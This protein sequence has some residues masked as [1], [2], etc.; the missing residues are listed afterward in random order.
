MNHNPIQPNG[1]PRQ[2]EVPA[3]AKAACQGGINAVGPISATREAAITAKLYKLIREGLDTAGIPT[4]RRRQGMLRIDALPRPIGVRI[5]C[6][7]RP[8]PVWRITFGECG[9]GDW[10]CIFSPCE[11]TLHL[12]EFGPHTGVAL[13]RLLREADW[14]WPIFEHDRTYP[15]YAWSRLAMNTYESDRLERERRK[16]TAKEGRGGQ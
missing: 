7:C 10:P 5:Q 14:R 13:A 4:G 12:S 1:S 3:H 16:Q 9:C 8:L 15:R 2:P 6:Y 11:L